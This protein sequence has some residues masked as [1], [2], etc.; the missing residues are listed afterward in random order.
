MAMVNIL[1]DKGADIDIGDDNGWSALFFACQNGNYEVT[2]LLLE[3]GADIKKKTKTCVTCLMVAVRPDIPEMIQ[4]LIGKGADIDAQDE[5]GFAPIHF[6]AQENCITAARML[7]EAGAN[8]HSI[9]SV[10]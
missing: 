2:Q 10:L 6:C 8:L 4:L 5:H 9:A 3:R 1:I 7:I